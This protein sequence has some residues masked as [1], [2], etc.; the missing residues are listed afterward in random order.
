VKIFVKKIDENAGYCREYY[1]DINT[2]ALYCTVDGEFHTCTVDG[3]PIH[4]L[5]KDIEVRI[6]PPSCNLKY[7]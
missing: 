6:I 1:K 4:P 3:E 7:R 5:R 2:G